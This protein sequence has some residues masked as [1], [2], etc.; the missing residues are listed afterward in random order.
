MVIGQMDAGRALAAAAAKGRTAE[1][2]RILEECRVAADTRNEFGKTAL[3]VGSRSSP[4]PR[5]GPTG[6][7][8]G[9]RTLRLLHIILPVQICKFYISSLR[10][11]AQ[12]ALRS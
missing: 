8:T 4:Q 5:H 6:A 10:N 1:V 11:I 2:L 3:Q 7:N 12:C 9:I